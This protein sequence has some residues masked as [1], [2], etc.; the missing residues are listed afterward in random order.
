MSMICKRRERKR[1]RSPPSR[2]SRGRIANLPLHQFER[3]EYRLAIRGNAQNP[4]CK[5]IALQRSKTGKFDYFRTPNQPARSRDSEFFTDDES[6][7]LERQW[8][9]SR[10]LFQMHLNFMEYSLI[11]TLG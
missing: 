2:R 10:Q 11:T 7:D 9:S 6:I 5:E 8:K 3:E 1:S 4:I